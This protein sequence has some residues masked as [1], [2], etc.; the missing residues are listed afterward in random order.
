MQLSGHLFD[1]CSCRVVV[2]G[3]N[4]ILCYVFIC[5]NVFHI[6]SYLYLFF[7]CKFSRYCKI[8]DEV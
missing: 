7:P 5:V 8:L 1:I 4:N 6:M 2:L 3:L